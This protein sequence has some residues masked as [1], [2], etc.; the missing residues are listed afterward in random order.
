MWQKAILAIL[1]IYFLDVWLRERLAASKA[2]KIA[3]Q[4]GKPFLNVG[5]GTPRSSM[6]GGKLRGDINC[7]LA[8][9]NT[10]SCSKT[11]ICH[12][13]VQD[14]SRFKDKQFG[15]ALIANVMQYVPNKEKAMAELHR[16]ADEVIIVDNLIPWMQLGPGPKFRF[17]A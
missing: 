13:D 12:C 7:D 11:T 17:T 1:V 5:S 8:A 4:L 2:R 14:L 15:V 3:A 9:A 16:V 6:T 10:I